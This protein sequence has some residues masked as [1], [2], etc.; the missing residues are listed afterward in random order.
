MCTILDD[1]Q[2][3]IAP[4]SFLFPPFSFLFWFL[5]A[6][7]HLCDSLLHGLLTSTRMNGPKRC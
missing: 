2:P 5:R 4:L 6:S 7:L 3:V 1:A